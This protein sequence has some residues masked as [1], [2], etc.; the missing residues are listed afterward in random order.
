MGVKAAHTV[1]MQPVQAGEGVYMQML[2]GPD[3]GPHFA[4]RRFTIRAGGWMPRHTNRV[5]HE[6][7]VLQGRGRIAIGEEV[8]EV[9]AGDVVFIPAGVAHWYRNIGAEDFVF[10]CA[11]PNLPDE[12]T[13]LDPQPPTG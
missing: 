3:E 4:L 8:L 7:Y 9:Q 2:I 12:I 1:P 6:Q 10:L 11:V 5:E 13:I